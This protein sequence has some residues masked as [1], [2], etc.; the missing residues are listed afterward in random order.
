MGHE[1]ADVSME[2]DLEATD[3]FEPKE[4]DHEARDVSKEAD[5]EVQDVWKEAD[6]EAL[7]DSKAPVLE[8]ADVFDRTE[9]VR[10]ATVSLLEMKEVVLLVTVFVQMEAH[11]EEEVYSVSVF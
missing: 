8:E 9:S 7:D 11:L 2:T 4:A 5:H 1:E 10:E 6:R 3:V